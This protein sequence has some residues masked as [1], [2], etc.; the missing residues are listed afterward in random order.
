MWDTLGKYS[1]V[2]NM[3][4]IGRASGGMLVAVVDGLM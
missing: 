4:S 3:V 2:E 1:T